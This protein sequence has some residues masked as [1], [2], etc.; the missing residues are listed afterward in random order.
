MKAVMH[1]RFE[2]VLFRVLELIEGHFFLYF[3]FLYIIFI[4]SKKEIYFFY[5]LYREEGEFNKKQKNNLEIK[6]KI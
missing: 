6:I 4:Y 3:I 1:E 2:Y 5:L